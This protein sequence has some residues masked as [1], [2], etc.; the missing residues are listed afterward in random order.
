M[1]RKAFPIALLLWSVLWS[2]VLLPGRAASQTCTTTIPGGV[3][4][5][6]TWTTAG[7]PYCVTGDITVSLLTIEPGVQVLVD[8]PFKIEVLT[9]I[10]AIGTAAE[11][12]L[13]SAKD[14]A[15]TENLWHGLKFQSTPAGSN[16][17]H[18]IIEH[19][20]D[21]GLSLINS[22]P[23]LKNI[24][25]RNNS[26]TDTG[27]GLDAVIDEG[28][29]VLQDCTVTDNTSGSHGGGI[30]AIM[31]TG[32]LRL[33]RCV[34][35]NNTANISNASRNAVGGGIRVN[36]NSEFTNCQIMGNTSFSN[37][38]SNFCG[39]VGRGGGLYSALGH[40]SLRNCMIQDN[41]A[42]AIE[43]ESTGLGKATSRGGGIYLDSGSLGLHNSIVSC[44]STTAAGNS[45]S[46][47]GSGIY[48]SAG[49]ADIDHV[50]VA[51]NNNHGLR[52]AGGVV[53]IT[54]S[55]FYF[56]NNDGTQISGTVTA[57]YSDIQETPIFPGMGNI[58]FNPAFTGLECAAN[59]L[60]LLPGSPAIDAGDPEADDDACFPP[61][62]GA[63]RNDMGAYGGPLACDF[64]DTILSVSPSS[65]HFGSVDVGASSDPK[66]L[67]IANVG[68]SNLQIGSITTTDGTEF[69]IQNDACSEQVIL[70]TASCMLDIVFSPS[71]LGSQSATL[72]IPSNDMRTP[73]F[74]TPLH[75]IG[76]PLM[77]D[78]DSGELNILST[79]ASPGATATVV[80][81][82]NTAPHEVAAFGFEVM[83]DAA[84]LTF[85]EFSRGDLT[86][87][88][89]T[90]NAS[91]PSPGVVRVGGFE[92]EAGTIA[93]GS[94]GSVVV[95]NFSVDHNV[96]FQDALPVSLQN[97]VDDVATFSISDGCVITGCPH[98]CDV[99]RD[100][101][102]TPQDAL[103]A[104][105][106]FLRL[107]D[108]PL[109]VCQQDHADVVEPVDPGEGVTSEDALCCFN[110]FL[111]L[112]SCLD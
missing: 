44:N 83:Y 97:L 72:V 25:L 82:I 80:V 53:A 109:D 3:V 48:V 32:S 84:Q 56:N 27:G 96:P 46:T 5:G 23:I 104:F 47:E 58:N 81:E 12:I 62:Q 112:P 64:F 9:T 36:G 49:T 28:D 67:T 43:S 75:G 20:S 29:L 63:A 70:P 88:F 78:D 31:G 105:R 16:L 108:P 106:Y 77:C 101:G 110:R 7:S 54:N 107:A 42:R 60:E 95:L 93:A 71:S 111:G 91:M 51:R 100:G 74:G 41:L 40:A 76:G 11:P 55:I 24:I 79:S 34:V 14:P 39:S 10:T 4:V 87:D 17:T 52:R 94:S 98:D 33:S 85:D 13:F 6:E 92:P 73:V 99:N 18:C 45:T 69:A 21:S 2:I 26:T 59:D 66:Q 68:E 38:T 102:I 30:N 19:S 65:F 89:N 1:F 8:G 37:C 50:T 35:S 103:L 22:S 86:T 61:S 90:L 57:T 15:D